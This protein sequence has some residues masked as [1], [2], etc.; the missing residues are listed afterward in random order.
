MEVLLKIYLSIGKSM[1]YNVK[2]ND[3]FEDILYIVRS[4]PEKLFLKKTTRFIYLRETLIL[5]FHMHL[6]H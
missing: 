4:S 2:G 1:V 3:I 5:I 6:T